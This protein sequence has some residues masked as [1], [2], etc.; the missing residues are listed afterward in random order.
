MMRIHDIICL[1]IVGQLRE[2]EAI[3]VSS[4]EKNKV[5]TE[6]GQYN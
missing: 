3:V 1:K 5:E 6:K 4:T 2:H